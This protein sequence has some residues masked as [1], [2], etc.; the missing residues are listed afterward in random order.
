MG[1]N[2][3]IGSNGNGTISFFFVHGWIFFVAWIV[4]GVFQIATARYMKHK[5]ETNMVLHAASGTL[6]TFATAFWGFWSI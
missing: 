5:W 4:F 2:L 6:I 1:K 3:K